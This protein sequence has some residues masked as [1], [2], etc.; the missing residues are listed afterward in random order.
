MRP[1]GRLLA[2][3]DQ[4]NRLNEEHQATEHQSVS[5]WSEST[6]KGVKTSIPPTL[7]NG[8]VIPKNFDVVILATKSKEG[9]DQQLKADGLGPSDFPSFWS[10]TWEKMPCTPSVSNDN[11][12]SNFWAHI[13]KSLRV[14]DGAQPWDRL[15]DMFLREEAA[16]TPDQPLFVL[17]GFKPWKYCYWTYVMISSWLL[18]QYLFMVNIRVNFHLLNRD[19]S[20]FY[21]HW[22]IFTL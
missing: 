3:G 12:N 8:P 14:A 9:G 1:G 10:P 6:R 17:V 11:D 5:V 21:G 20:V 13:A 18:C 4:T 7:N 15:L 22:G 19:T 2:S 16:T